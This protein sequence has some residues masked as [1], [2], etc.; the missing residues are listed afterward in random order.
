[1]TKPSTRRRSA[2]L[3]QLALVTSL[4]TALF[5]AC[6]G[7]G[8]YGGDSPPPPPPPPGAARFAGP[9]SSQPLALTADNA[10]L[11]VANEDNNSVTFFEVRGDANRKIAEVAVQTEPSGVA[12]LP[13]GSKAY[14]ANTVSGTVS[15]IPFNT[16]N[17]TVGTP[18]KHVPVGT[19]PASLVLTP[20]GRRL[21]VANSRS[22]S[23][24]VIDTATDAVVKTIA[25]VGPEPRGLAVSNDGD[26]DDTDETLYVT[27]FL[28]LPVAGKID[29]ADDAKDGH[30]ILL[31]TADNEPLADVAVKPMVDTG[32]KALGD[33]LA[34]QTPP[35]APNVPADFKFRTGAYA[36]QLNNIAIKGNYAFVPNTGASP[37]G[38]FRFNVNTQSLLSVIDRTRR[39]DAGQTINM[40]LAVEEQTATPKLFVTQPWAMAFKT[41]SDD[42]YVVS[43][44]SN[45]LVKLKVNPA[46]GAA[47]VQKEPGD[48]TRVL[49][50]AV[51]KNPRGIVVNSTDTRA[52]VAN[53]I[54]RDVSVVD[55]AAARENVIATLTSAALPAA[56]SLAEKAHIGKELYNTSVGLFDPAPGTTTAIAGRMSN[57]GW[58][59]CASCHTPKGLSDNVVWIFP[60]GPKRTISQHTDFDLSVANRSAQRALNW[61]AERDEQEDFELN[62]R[63]VSGGQGLVVLADGVT[64]DTN[65]VNL[66][67][68]NLALPSLPSGGR[69]QLKV[70]GVNAWDA[71]KAFIQF[72]IRAPISPLA[73]TNPLVAAG[74]EL[75]K[76]ANCQ[77]C[78]GGAQ[79][80]RSTIAFL[81]PP[82]AAAITAGQLTNQLANVGTFDAGFFNEVTTN[83]V[84]STAGTLGFVPPSLLSLHAFPNTFLHNGVATS[85]GQVLDNLGHRSAGTAGV[86]SLGSAADRD[87]LVQFLLSIDAK[88]EPISP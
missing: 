51:G 54:S 49:Q 27:Q 40:H 21:Y 9:T 67:Q 50:I 38:P 81:P 75:F 1:M 58:G 43:A 5:V 76:A 70:R 60:S 88:T 82:D 26:D 61:S 30:V 37:N 69:N 13:D 11:V 41:R 56:G 10:Y 66:R 39:L 36:N 78:H 12:F 18:S 47:V 33:A 6:G 19:E 57:N 17:G 85:L 86:D 15:V 2:H 14:V 48:A 23:I 29:G 32:F 4:S 72:G 59:S 80:T 71:I 8:G 7:G 3:A 45:H 52:Y 79:W 74:R 73:P 44:A 63:A 77:S 55:L 34:R 68:A 16:A 46:T 31:S 24:S 87:K 35:P 84:G 22:G 83:G 64:P 42:A 53:F 25:N 62:I 28:S 65:V 20:N